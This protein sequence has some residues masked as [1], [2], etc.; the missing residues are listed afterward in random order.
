MVEFEFKS[1]SPNCSTLLFTDDDCIKVKSTVINPSDIK[2]HNWEKLRDICTE[3]QGKCRSAH[4][5]W[6][7]SGNHN[8]DFMAHCKQLDI[9]HLW[10][11]PQIHPEVLDHVIAKLPP[12]CATS[13]VETEGS[14]KCDGKPKLTDSARKKRKQMEPTDHT[15]CL[16]DMTDSHNQP[17]SVT[18]D[19]NPVFFEEENNWQKKEV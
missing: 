12:G 1:V 10:K 18:V 3:M 2:S 15:T 6:K 9:C 11:H 14:G 17:S 4:A 8:P 13:S 5:N 7:R 16:K 19:N